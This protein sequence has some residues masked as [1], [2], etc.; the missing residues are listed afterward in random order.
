MIVRRFAPLR[1]RAGFSLI[2]VMAATLILGVVGYTLAGAVQMAERSHASVANTVDQNTAV[3]RASSKLRA[4]LRATS[5]NRIAVTTLP[6]GNH[7]LEFQVPV[8]IAGV[9]GW[10]ALDR[11][12]GSLEAQQNLPDGQLRY[13]VESMPGGADKR[14]VREVIDAAGGVRRRDVLVR[15]L[16]TTGAQAAF[17]VSQAG[18]L[19]QVQVRQAGKRGGATRAEEF[20][21]RTRNQ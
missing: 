19:W 21:V 20:H 13:T 5:D 18:A 4:E 11:R 2:E 12:L 1:R 9:A 6:D 14:L 3:R 16:A 8:E 15:G 7:R 10:G 17:S